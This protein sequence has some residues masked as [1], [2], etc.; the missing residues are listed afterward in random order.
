MKKKL[1]QFNPPSCVFLTFMYFQFV[2]EGS[3][4]HSLINS[5]PRVSRSQ[6][7]T[8]SESETKKSRTLVEP[9]TKTRKA[10]VL[11]KSRPTAKNNLIPQTFKSKVLNSCQ[12]S[13]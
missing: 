9:L 12:Q 3:E 13:S 7:L 11:N 10:K 4:A 8:K 5:E 2:P 1:T 6:D